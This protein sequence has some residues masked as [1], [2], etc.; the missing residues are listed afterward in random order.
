MSRAGTDATTNDRKHPNLNNNRTRS[1]SGLRL[2]NI[3]VDIP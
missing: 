1:K 2:R 3:H